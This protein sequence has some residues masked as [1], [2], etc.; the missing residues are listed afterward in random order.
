MLTFPQIDPTAFYLGPLPVRWYGLMYMFSFLSGWGLMLWRSRDQRDFWTTDRLSDL[1]FYLAIGVV[2]GGRVGYVLVYQ[3]AE[4]LSDPLLLFKAWEG[5]MSF[6]G[7]LVGVLLAAWAFSRKINKPFLFLMD[8]VAPVVPL[9][10]FLGRIGNFINGELWGRAS[11]VPWAMVFPLAGGYARHPSQLY[12]ALGEGL[13]LL[14]LLL[15]FARKPRPTGQ[16]SACFLMGYAL[17][18]FVLEFTRQPDVQLGF[19]AFDWLT[20]G[21]LLSIPMLLFGIAIWRVSN[22]SEVS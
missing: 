4:F 18:R 5:G 10:L 8:F 17:I 6:H 1:V 3:F 11:D 22:R 2:L 15:W 13:L 14:L 9:G 12:E 20:V 7:G 19:I 16:I 21:Q